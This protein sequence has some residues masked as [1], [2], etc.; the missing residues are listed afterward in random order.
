M[1]QCKKTL[2]NYCSDRNYHGL[3]HYLQDS[4]AID[5]THSATDVHLVSPG[6]SVITPPSGGG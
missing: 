4:G 2:M 5:E 3:F 6:G 1:A